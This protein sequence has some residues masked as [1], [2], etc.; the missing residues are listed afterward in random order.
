MLHTICCHVCVACSF[1]RGGDDNAGQRVKCYSVLN[2]LHLRNVNTT[3]ETYF[4]NKCA[5]IE[6]NRYYV[7]CMLLYYTGT[8]TFQ[9][10]YYV[11]S[12]AL[13]LM[14]TLRTDGIR[15]VP[16][17][18]KRPAWLQ[19]SFV[20]P[21]FYFGSPLCHSPGAPLL[22]SGFWLRAVWVSGFHRLCVLLPL[23]DSRRVQCIISQTWY[24][25]KTS[26]VIG[27]CLASAT[28]F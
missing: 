11:H 28:S 23:C 22:K 3:F 17:C 7:F 4:R 13:D 19:V 18:L 21:F 9:W 27:Q 24:S 1:P 14:T 15:A 12:F 6:Y 2:T 20:S 25:L 26:N 16:S 8:S 10:Y 5:V